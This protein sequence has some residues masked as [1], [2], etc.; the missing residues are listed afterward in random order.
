[1]SGLTSPSTAHATTLAVS[2][3]VAIARPIQIPPNRRHASSNYHYYAEILQPFGI[4]EG[5]WHAFTRQFVNSNLPTRNQIVVL[6]TMSIVLQAAFVFGLGPPGIP[7]AAIASGAFVGGPLYY[8]IKGHRLRHNVRNRNI[9]DWLSAWNTQYF[10]PKGLMIGF[11]LPGRPVRKA[12]VAPRLRK[13]TA[14]A[15]KYKR[16]KSARRVT[17]RPRIVIVKLHDPVPEAGTVPN[18]EPVKIAALWKY[19]C[20]AKLSRM[21]SSKL[22]AMIDTK[23]QAAH[24]LR[25][26]RLQAESLRLNSPSQDLLPEKDWLSQWWEQAAFVTATPQSA[27]ASVTSWKQRILWKKADNVDTPVRPIGALDGADASPVRT[28]KTGRR[29]RRRTEVGGAMLGSNRMHDALRH[30][31]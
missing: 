10:N 23:R 18:L 14:I 12:A 21:R 22:L 5:D 26:Q 16:P 2:Q 28:H 11:N 24:D 31:L 4:S 19:M 3:E 20:L 8:A 29:N 7:V 30:M 25:L 1:M 27:A 17:R 6:G 9:P 15:G 13:H